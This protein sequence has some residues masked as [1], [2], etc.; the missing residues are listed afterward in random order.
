LTDQGLHVDGQLHRYDE[1]RAF[2]VR[3]DGAL[4]QIVLIPVKRFGLS[5]TMYIQEEQGESI[6]DALGARLPMENV[7]ADAVDKLI[8]KLKI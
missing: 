3:R 8:R 1:F 6:V 2:G 4:W 5:L 7:Q